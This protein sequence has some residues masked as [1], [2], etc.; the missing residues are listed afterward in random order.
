MRTFSETCCSTVD[1]TKILLHVLM[2]TRRM[3][4]VFLLVGCM[5]ACLL[6]R[7][8]VRSLSAFL[9]VYLLDACLSAGLLA[10]LLADLLARRLARLLGCWVGITYMRHFV[11]PS[12][13]PLVVEAECQMIRRSNPERQLSTSCSF[14]FQPYLLAA[15]AIVIAS[16]V[17]SLVVALLLLSLSTACPPARRESLACSLAGGRFPPQ[18]GT[19]DSTI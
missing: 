13:S 11:I 8:F 6:V 19:E 9:L 7:S 4:A 18:E 5:H 12:L 15:A 10:R 17:P 16:S 3:H 2:L 14:R 1:A